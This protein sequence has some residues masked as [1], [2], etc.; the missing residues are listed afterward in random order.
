M[1]RGMIYTIITGIFLILALQLVAADIRLTLLTPQAQF[2]GQINQPIEY[3]IGVAVGV[4][5][6]EA[7]PESGPMPSDSDGTDENNSKLWL[8]IGGILLVIAIIIIVYF[9]IKSKKTPDYVQ[10]FEELN[11]TVEQ[12]IQE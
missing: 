9:Y 8:Y 5:V 11:Q 4:A 6:G 7:V 3:Y 10:D 2:E 1:K 12:D